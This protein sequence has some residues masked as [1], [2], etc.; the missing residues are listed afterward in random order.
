M[1][2]HIV[3][4]RFWTCM[5]YIIRLSYPTVD[6]MWA[7]I[8]VS[9]SRYRR[10]VCVRVC[11]CI[12]H[13]LATMYIG[14][15]KYLWL[16]DNLKDEE[17]MWAK[18]IVGPSLLHYNL[19]AQKIVV[20]GGGRL[21]TCQ[22]RALLST[23]PGAWGWWQFDWILQA[24]ALDIWS[25]RVYVSLEKDT[26]MLRAQIIEGIIFSLLQHHFC[27]VR[28]TVSFSIS[29]KQMLL[30]HLFFCWLYL[31]SPEVSCWFPAYSATSYLFDF[32][33]LFLLFLFLSFILL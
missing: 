8:C 21:Y 16:G 11:V 13:I 12:Y 29:S 31:I 24:N 22:L 28:V 19:D 32:F 3:T 4:S 15:V 25:I 9:Y 23:H 30:C 2:E 17:F 10:F 7:G 33:L 1:P 6:Q 14:V 5:I 26:S 20:G 27:R 18:A